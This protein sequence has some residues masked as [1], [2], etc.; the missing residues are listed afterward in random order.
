M[1]LQVGLR[2]WS[3]GEIFGIKIK[4]LWGGAHKAPPPIITKVNMVVYKIQGVD[5]Y[6]EASVPSRRLLQY[7]RSIFFIYLGENATPIQH[8][9]LYLY[10]SSPLY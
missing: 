6:G 2:V 8:L 7:I 1:S 4:T 10:I 5:I 9:T 3:G